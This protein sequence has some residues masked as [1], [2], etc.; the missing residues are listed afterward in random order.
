MESWQVKGGSVLPSLDANW[1]P[2]D[3]SVE[4]DNGMVGV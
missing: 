3:Q 4:K 2:V 1:A